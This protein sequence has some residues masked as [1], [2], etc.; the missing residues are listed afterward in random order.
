MKFFS[1]YFLNYPLILTYM[2]QASEYRPSEYLR[3]WWRTY[4]FRTNM[5]R[6]SLDYTKKATLLLLCNRIVYMLAV[7]S[8][9]I[10]FAFGLY[11]QSYA[12]LVVA[13]LCLLVMPI[14]VSHYVIPFLWLG[15]V[16]IQK[17]QEKK[18]I[19]LARQRLS[20]HS[21]LKIAIAGSYGKT[22]TKEA[23]YA[24]LSEGKSVAATPG[25]YNTLMG[26]SRFAKTINGN[27]DILIFELG[28]SHVGDI[29]ELS[30]LTKPDLGIITGINEAHLSTFGTID[31]TIKTIFELKD[32]LGD[33]LLYKNYESEY[34]RQAIERDEQSF[35][36]KGMGG[37]SVTEAMT[38]LDGTSFTA[39]RGT[40][41]IK[42]HV[43][44]LGEHNIGVLLAIIDIATNLGLTPAQ[45][46]AGLRKLQVVD[47]RLQPRNIGGAWVIDDTY[48]GN[49]EGIEAGLTVLASIKAKRKIYVTPGLVEQGN[50]S[51]E[52]HEKIGRLVAPV[53]DHVV[54]M[55]NSTTTH[56]KKGLKDAHFKG[57]ITV[58]DD[59]LAYY[60][61]LEHTVAAGDVLL[62]QNDWTDNYA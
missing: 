47:H 4:D 36:R 30:E 33:K 38:T 8:I 62:M 39:S 57:E 50:K 49:I 12:A 9:L 35:T 56:I 5:S 7:I 41:K 52:I 60:T 45:I 44:L 3:W 43:K 23:L 26:I 18:N 27:E 16:V 55:R 28:E 53:A 13:G 22:T 58:V 25:N 40:V 29:K 2:L 10:L 61:N 59:P 42:A 14:V 37:W 32:Y 51:Q 34:V 19:E 21:A 31:N 17:P 15:K 54:L 24:V 20:N 1:R 48:N 11:V 6:K 46:E